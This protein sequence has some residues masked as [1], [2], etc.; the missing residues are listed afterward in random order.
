MQL[1]EIRERLSKSRET[2]RK[3]IKVPQTFYQ[4]FLLLLLLLRLRSFTSSYPQDYIGAEK[5]KS[6]IY[7]WIWLPQM[8]HLSLPVLS[9]FGSIAKPS[10]L[11]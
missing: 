1:S 5:K 9:I 7:N 4:V 6:R 11:E 2:P 10:L 3:C 8:H